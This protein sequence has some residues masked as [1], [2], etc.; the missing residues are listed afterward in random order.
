MLSQYLPESRCECLWAM[1][2]TECVGTKFLDFAALSRT[3]AVVSE[4]AEAQAAVVRAGAQAPQEPASPDVFSG[5]VPGMRSSLPAIPSTAATT[6][7]PPQT[8]YS[9]GGM[10]QSPAPSQYGQVPQPFRG[11][12]LQNGDD[13]RMQAAQQPYMGSYAG[14]QA[15]PVQ[16]KKG[17]NPFA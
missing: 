12:G 11:L 16:P 8:A 15:G 2:C 10:Q 4:N 14:G 1:C 7:S 13:Y 5:L 9:N 6:N 3:G 17:G